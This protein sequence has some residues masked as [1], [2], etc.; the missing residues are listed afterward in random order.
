MVV[1]LK[2]TINREKDRSGQ[3]QDIVQN[4][5]LSLVDTDNKDFEKNICKIDVDELEVSNDFI[6]FFYNAMKQHE[7]EELAKLG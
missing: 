2:A 4:I 6:M 5:E 7:Q 3:T 1:N